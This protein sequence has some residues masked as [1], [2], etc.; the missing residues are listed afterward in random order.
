MCL[1]QVCNLLC[2]HASMT[3]ST[4]N[5]IRLITGFAICHFERSQLPKHKNHPYL[6]IRII[7]CKSMMRTNG[8]FSEPRPG[9]LLRHVT[10][11]NDSHVWVRSASGGLEALAPLFR[12]ETDLRRDGS[13]GQQTAPD[14]EQ[15]WYPEYDSDFLIGESDQSVYS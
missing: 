13:L 2:A 10:R 12:H 3:K 15:P 7:D 9:A 5:I 4:T 8:S 14:S 1:T 6:V 11:F